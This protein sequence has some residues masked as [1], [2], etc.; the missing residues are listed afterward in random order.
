MPGIPIDLHETVGHFSRRQHVINT[1]GQVRPSLHIRGS[2][3]TAAGVTTGRDPNRLY[4]RIKR[5]PN[6][7]NKRDASLGNPKARPSRRRRA[8][9][10]F[11]SR[12]AEDLWRRT[13]RDSVSNL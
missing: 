1:F 8:Y 9:M 11:G 10:G 6:L 5:R 3:R 12:R 7:M 13:I 2:E 4:P